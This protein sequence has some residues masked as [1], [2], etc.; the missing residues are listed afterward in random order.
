M[1]APAGCFQKEDTAINPQD[2]SAAAR[3]YAQQPGERSLSRLLAVLQG[4]LSQGAPAVLAMDFPAPGLE[5]LGL[6]PT[7]VRDASGEEYYALVTSQAKGVEER[8]LIEMDLAAALGMVAGDPTA[9]G[10]CINPWNEPPCY[11]A[12]GHLR[13]LLRAHADRQAGAP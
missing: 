8:L 7:M 5:H 12:R 1:A 11:L 9:A 10:L 2:L 6:P 13:A 3:A 4:L